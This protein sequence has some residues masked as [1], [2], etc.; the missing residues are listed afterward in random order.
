MGIESQSDSASSD[1]SRN[2]SCHIYIQVFIY[3]FVFFD[4]FQRKITPSG[5]SHD[6]WLSES[7]RRSLKSTSY[8]SVDS[9]KSSLSS[10][11]CS[12]Y[13]YTVYGAL[14]KHLRLLSQ[15]PLS[16]QTRAGLYSAH[17]W[18]LGATLIRFSYI[19]YAYSVN[20][21]RATLDPNIGLMLI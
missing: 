17:I 4:R 15:S 6:S 16:K 11:M 20:I 19:S 1:H 14:F 13:F 3:F 10:S 21:F 2:C 9:D 8:V 5:G 18:L 7:E 12:Y